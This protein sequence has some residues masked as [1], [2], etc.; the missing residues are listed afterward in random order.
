[1]CIR[2][3]YQRRVHGDSKLINIFL[4]TML[5]KNQA[6]LFQDNFEVTS[7]NRQHFQRVSRIDARSYLQKI[8]MQLDVNSEIYP[9]KAGEIFEIAIVNNIKND[10]TPDNGIY[11]ADDLKS[12][13]ILDRYEYAMYGKVFKVNEEKG[14]SGLNLVVFASFGGLLMSLKGAEPSLKTIP[15]DSRIYLLIKKIQSICASINKV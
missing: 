9:M 14:E 13:T 1:M 6:P 2:D 12:S 10:G 5:S 8:D 11:D 4:C 15:Y 7:V 3:R